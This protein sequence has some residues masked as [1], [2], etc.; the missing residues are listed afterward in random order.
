MQNYPLESSAQFQSMLSVCWEEMTG[1]G[2]VGQRH[3][4]VQLSVIQGTWCS[5]T[6]VHPLVPQ[7]WTRSCTLDHA[8]TIPRDAAYHPCPTGGTEG[9]DVTE[10]LPTVAALEKVSPLR[11]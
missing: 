6:L 8:Q 2:N 9:A 4:Y 11:G 10:A 3:H 7:A 1:K 5:H